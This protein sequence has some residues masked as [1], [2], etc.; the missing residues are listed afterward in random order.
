MRT[1]YTGKNRRIS[2]KRE[3]SKRQYVNVFL[4]ITI[5]LLAIWTVAG[6]YGFWKLHKMKQYRQELYTVVIAASKENTLIRNQIKAFHSNRKFQEEMVRKKLGWIRRNELLYRFIGQGG[7][8][9][10]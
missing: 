8:T 6:P 1:S 2:K 9:Q 3:Y 5:I 4:G 7:S 10:R